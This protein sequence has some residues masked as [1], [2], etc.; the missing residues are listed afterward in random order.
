MLVQSLLTCQ[1]CPLVLP[2]FFCHM[3]IMEAKE[4]GCL[5][6]Q[7]SQYLTNF[8]IMQAMEYVL[9]VTQP[10]C[11]NRMAIRQVRWEK[12]STGWVKLNTD[13]S[14]D[15]S[16]GFVGGGRLIRDDRGNWIMGSLENW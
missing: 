9:Y 4:L 15:A 2:I 14:A 8:I 12:P 16:S 7:R 13:G 1:R 6:Q 10:R 3:V 11:S 5:Q